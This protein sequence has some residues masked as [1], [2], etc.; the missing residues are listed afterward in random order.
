MK[1]FPD[2]KTVERLRKEYPAGTMVVLERMDDIQ[3]PP[4]G[5][6]GTVLGV[7]DTG[8]YRLLLTGTVITNKEIDPCLQHSELLI[9]EKAWL[10]FKNRKDPADRKLT[11]ACC[12]LI[13]CI[14]NHQLL[15]R[16]G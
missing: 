3:A 6:V 2:R 7:D 11:D 12:I 1:G 9:G 10:Q 5:T 8:R 14:P 15:P 4:P 13:E 16:D